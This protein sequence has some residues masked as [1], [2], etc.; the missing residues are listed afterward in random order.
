MIAVD[1]GELPALV[2]IVSAEIK[3][4]CNLDPRTRRVARPSFHIGAESAIN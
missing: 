4:D 2:Q 3:L 1:D